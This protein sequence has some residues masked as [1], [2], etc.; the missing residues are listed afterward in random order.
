MTALR[1]PQTVTATFDLHLWTCILI[2]FSYFRFHLFAAW[3][4]ALCGEEIENGTE[5]LT[6]C[7]V[8]RLPLL[9]L[10]LNVG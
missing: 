3:Y 5:S 1:L 4:L 2:V 7:I 9:A 6:F 8:W 10:C